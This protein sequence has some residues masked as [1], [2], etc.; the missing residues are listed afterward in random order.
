MDREDE[1]LIIKAQ[2]GN[3]QAFEELVKKHDARVM[4]VIVNMVQNV[5]D[6]RD[7]YQDVFIKAFRSLQKFRFQSEFYTW[8]FRITINTC[9]SFRKK[10]TCDLHQSLDEHDENW[11]II[12]DTAI[13]NPEQQILN[14]EL[15]ENIQQSISQLSAK[16]RA[17]FILRHYHGHKLNEIAEILECSEGTVKNYLFRAV[18]K[19]K[20]SL[21]DY[22]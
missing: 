12:N 10:R 19:L 18:Q 7:L 14:S 15:A 22:Q 17:V 11:V 2:R 16:Q 13:L 9:I 20:R 21:Q 4:T 5:E 8:L 6:A 3:L 1:L